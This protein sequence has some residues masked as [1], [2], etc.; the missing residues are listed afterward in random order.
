MLVDGISGLV[1]GRVY[2]RRGPLTLLAVPIAA[3][4]SVIAFSEDAIW[5]WVGVAIWGIV[6]G[7]LDSTAKAVVTELV[8]RQTRAV[9]FGWLAFVRGVGLLLA[10][11]VLGVAYDAG[12]GYVVIFILVANAIAFAGLATTLRTLSR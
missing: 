7:V 1:M 11:A 4:G 12:T 8:P 10:G 3:A 2:D 5:I 6:N 9:A